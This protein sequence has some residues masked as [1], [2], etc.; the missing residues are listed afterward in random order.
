MVGGRKHPRNV[1]RSSLTHSNITR[2]I[3]CGKSIFF[4]FPSFILIHF[5]MF[6]YFSYCSPPDLSPNQGAITKQQET[7]YA[8]GLVIY[9]MAVSTS[10]ILIEFNPCNTWVFF[11]DVNGILMANTFKKIYFWF[12]RVQRLLTS[13]SAFLMEPIETSTSNSFQ[14]L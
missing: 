1:T 2:S 8:F 13:D 3:I 9:R 11:R 6:P 4:S 10:H 7:V 5:Y 14:T 12:I